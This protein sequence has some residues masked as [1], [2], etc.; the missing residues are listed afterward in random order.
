MILG[1]TNQERKAWNGFLVAYSKINQQI[2]TDLRQ[3]FHISHVEFEALLRLHWAEQN[4]LRIQELAALSIL[5]TSGMSR[6]IARLEKTG[7]VRREEACE[8]RRGAYAVMTSEGIERFQAI[9]EHHI[10][11]VRTVF[12]SHYTEIELDQM[13]EFWSRLN[14]KLPILKP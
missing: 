1:F 4:R 8:D 6:A 2:E 11:F 13:S 5:S 7:F 14:N 10:A 12:L 9:I 3:N